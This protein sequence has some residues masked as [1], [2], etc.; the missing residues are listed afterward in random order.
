MRRKA[1]RPICNWRA[2]AAL[3]MPAWYS[4]CTNLL[5]FA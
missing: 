4:D 5:T 3:L 1:V 2:I